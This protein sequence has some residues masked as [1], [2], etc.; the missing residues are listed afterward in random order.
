MKMSEKDFKE[1]IEMPFIQENVEKILLQYQLLKE[2]AESI[3]DKYAKIT[4]E[5]DL[6]CCSLNN[7]DVH[8]YYDLQ[9]INDFSI[10]LNDME[11][12]GEKYL[13][14]GD[15]KSYDKTLPIEYLW[16]DSWEEKLKQE[17]KLSW[18]N[19]LT[20]FDLLIACLNLS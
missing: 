15:Y 3:L 19:K 6:N 1:I 2:R 7:I 17:Q 16:D 4:K 14:Y 11:F 10:T 9:N 20:P 12:R 8:Y 13:G 18:F 5:E